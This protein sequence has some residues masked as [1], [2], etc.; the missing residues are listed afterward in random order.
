M[1]FDIELCK[2]QNMQVMVYTD[3]EA[4]KVVGGLVMG[5]YYPVRFRDA[6]PTL[7]DRENLHNLPPEPKPQVIRAVVFHN[8]VISSKEDNLGWFEVR[9]NDP[10][11]PKL[12]IVGDRTMTVEVWLAEH[13]VNIITDTHK[14]YYPCRDEKTRNEAVIA[15]VGAVMKNNDTQGAAP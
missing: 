13:G 9:W 6:T 8:E 12:I 1:S 3:K 10:Q 11:Y 14:K 7:I 2:K 4:W 15:A 5:D